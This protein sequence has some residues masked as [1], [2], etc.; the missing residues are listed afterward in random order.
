M[1]RIQPPDPVWLLSVDGDRLCRRLFDRHYSRRRA[2]AGAR[3]K[4]VGPGETIVLRSECGGAMW[5]WRKFIDD[6]DDGSGQPQRGINCS[7]FRNET[8]WL[9]SELVRQ[10]DRI[11]DFCWPGERHYTYVDASA[12]RSTNPGFCFLKAGWRRCGVTRGGLLILE[13]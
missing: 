10:A 6:A 9:A 12:V 11:A 4:F 7:V 1:G 2:R 8:A 13:R 5:V 3:G